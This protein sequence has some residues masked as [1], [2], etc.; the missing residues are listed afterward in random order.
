M[1]PILDQIHE[2]SGS[3]QHVDQ[4]KQYG[5]NVYHCFINELGVSS[6]PRQEKWRRGKLLTCRQPPGL[7]CCC[8]RCVSEAPSS[9]VWGRNQGAGTPPNARSDS[10]SSKRWSA[11]G[12]SCHSDSGW[13]VGWALAGRAPCPACNLNRN[14]NNKVTIYSATDQNQRQWLR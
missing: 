8:P 13:G 11:P 5:N 1:F 6:C 9:A 3:M 2:V 12:P 4:N 10:K 14:T 7:S